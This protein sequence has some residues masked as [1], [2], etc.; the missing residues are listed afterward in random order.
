MSGAEFLARARELR[1]DAMRNRCARAARHRPADVANRAAVMF[2]EMSSDERRVRFAAL[3]FGWSRRL[4]RML[5]H[6][7][8]IRRS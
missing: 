6:H 8:M 2:D 3:P 1:P 4:H 7:S 5:L